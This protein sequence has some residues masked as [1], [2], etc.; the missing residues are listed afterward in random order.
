METII[1]WDR[2]LFRF[3]NQDFH[4]EAMDFLMYYISER[5]F[6]FPVYILVAIYLVYLYRGKALWIIL[7]IT[8]L[9]ASTD[10]ISSQVMK[11]LVQRHRPCREE[12]D[13]GFSVKLLPGA[14]CSEYGFVSSHATNTYGMAVFFGLLFY[15][16][17][18][19]WLWG[20]LLWASVIGFSRIYLGQHYP[21]DIVGGAILGVAL[22]FLWNKILMMT[23]KHKE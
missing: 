3:I 12:V 10:I 20:G 13:L 11:K 22:A 9:I 23:L 8:L 1:Q 7:A 4:S 2:D 17:N 5:W 16:K 6:W 14:G 18:K 21:L 15:D 19:W